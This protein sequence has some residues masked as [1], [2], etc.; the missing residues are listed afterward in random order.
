MD[1]IQRGL[2]H[3]KKSLFLWST[4]ISVTNKRLIADEYKIFLFD[5]EV[6]R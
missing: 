6:K 2:D 1:I 3:Q 5:T 4:E